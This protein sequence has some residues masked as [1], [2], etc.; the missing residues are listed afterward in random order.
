MNRVHEVL[1]RTYPNCTTMQLNLIVY[2]MMCYAVRDT[3]DDPARVT[4]RNY[5]ITI[6]PDCRTVMNYFRLPSHLERLQVLEEDMLSLAYEMSAILQLNVGPVLRLIERYHRTVPIAEVLGNYIT[7]TTQHK[8]ILRIL[9][10]GTVPKHVH[11]K[12]DVHQMEQNLPP[13]LL[14]I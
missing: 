3:R 1:E 12:S 4:Q 11:K 9:A 10:T 2:G 8:D 7:E 5:S 13:E 6:P 14:N